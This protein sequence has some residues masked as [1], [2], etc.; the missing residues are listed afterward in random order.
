MKNIVIIYSSPEK[1][2]NSESM[3]NA[4][5]EGMKKNKN[6]EISKIYLRDYNFADYC[7]ANKYPTQKTEPEF[8]NFAKKIEKADGLIIATPTFNFNVPSRLKNV[9]DRIGFIALDYS[10]KNMIGQPVQK[11]VNLRTFFLVSGGSPRI[12]Q[13]FLFFLFPSFW[14]FVV[15]KYYGAKFCGSIY[16]GNL[17]FK[18]PASQDKKLMNK[19]YKYGTKFSNNL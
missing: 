15:F 16:G 7:H 1:N 4:F 14:L 17:T 10:K 11:L 3:A 12:V 5:L 18:N 19:C 6:L 2:S 8:Y 9:I 13:F